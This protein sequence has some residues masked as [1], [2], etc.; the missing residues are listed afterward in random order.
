MRTFEK[1]F[2]YVKKSFSM[3]EKISVD[4]KVQNND[5]LI[6]SI[7]PHSGK[8]HGIRGSLYFKFD[9]E[10]IGFFGYFLPDDYIDWNDNSWEKYSEKE[11]L[12][13]LDKK[14]EEYKNYIDN[15]YFFTFY[16]EHDI[17]KN[18]FAEFSCRHE[19]L[20]N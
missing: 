11:I 7:F 14:I 10:T 19:R 1:Y 15:G 12:E 16:N 9:Q 20:C 3:Y 5:T 17:E 6:I 18:Q 2:E 13:F 4:I 8:S